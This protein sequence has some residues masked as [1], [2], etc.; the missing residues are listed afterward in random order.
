MEAERAMDQVV[1]VIQA[2]LMDISVLQDLEVM[3]K[4]GIMIDTWEVVA[5]EDQVIEEKVGILDIVVLEA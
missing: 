1:M 4:H 2:K 5:M 3:V